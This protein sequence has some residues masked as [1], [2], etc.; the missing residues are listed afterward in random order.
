MGMPLFIC[1]LV[2]GHLNHFPFLMIS[3]SVVLSIDLYIHVNIMLGNVVHESILILSIQHIFCDIIKPFVSVDF[4]T[5][6]ILLPFW[7]NQ[8][9]ILSITDYF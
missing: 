9:C 6:Y 1:S 4:K 5:H 8:I 2:G 7:K 3:N